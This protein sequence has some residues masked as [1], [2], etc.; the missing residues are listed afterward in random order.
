MDFQNPIVL[1]VGKRTIATSYGSGGT[2]ARLSGAIGGVGGLK[3]TGGL[4]LELTAENTYT[5][6]TEVNA[7]ILRLSNPL[8]LPGGIGASGGLGNLNFSGGNDYEYGIWSGS[9]GTYYYSTGT[10]CVV[11]LNSENFTRT[12]G[13][14]PHKFNS[15]AAADSA[16]FGADSAVNLGGESASG[17][18]LESLRAR[19]QQLMLQ[20]H[21]FQ[22]PGG[23]PEYHRFRR[24]R[25]YDCSGQRRRGHRCQSQWNSFRNRRTQKKWRG[26]ARSRRGNTYQGPTIIRRG[27]LVLS[28][29]GS[30]ASSSLIDVQSNANFD[31]TAKTVGF[32]LG[33]GQTLQ[34]SG[35]VSGSVIADPGSYI[36]PGDGRGTLTLNNSL[37]LEFGTALIFDLDTQTNSDKISL[38]TLIL[39]G[40]QFS[41]FTFNTLGGFGQGTYI[42]LEASTAQ[43]A[44][45]EDNAGSVGGLPAS[46][47]V[48]GNYLAS[49]SSPSL[50]PSSWPPPARNRVYR[51]HR[52]SEREIFPLQGIVK[53]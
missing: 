32:H 5:G 33:S 34:G 45:S 52:T 12:L 15:P 4:V 49:P 19:Q 48:S 26:K 37:S 7:G 35:I 44:L 31:V 21:V 20:F 51:L 24:F 36:A 29:E 53:D 18:G 25:P 16:H 43:G 11:E 10:V 42:L 2:H 17:L 6:E 46:L 22:C 3:K 30:I 13:T 40:Q 50:P 39:D 8:A 27:A 41:D 47:H 9:G 14:E 38:D 1:G 23:F 28:A